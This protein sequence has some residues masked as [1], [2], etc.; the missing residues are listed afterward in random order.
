[1]SIYVTRHIRPPEA[2]ANLPERPVGPPAPSRVP[3]S[4]R[5]V[6]Q[7][8]SRQRKAEPANYLLPASRAWIE[9]LPAGVRPSRL[10]ELYPRIAN[11]IAMDWNDGVRCLALLVELLVGRREYREGFPTDVHR[12]LRALR[13]H[14]YAGTLTLQE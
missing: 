13:D 10:P 7:D 14:H 5:A 1:M 9:G 12:E 11:L 8:F 2:G 6:R 3:A 4:P